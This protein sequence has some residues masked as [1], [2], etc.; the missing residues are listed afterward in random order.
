MQA[1]QEVKPRIRRFAAGRWECGVLAPFFDGGW[2]YEGMSDVRG[3]GASPAEAFK[4]W[5][6]KTENNRNTSGE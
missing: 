5:K 6:R 2:Q 3:V 1:G 4:Q